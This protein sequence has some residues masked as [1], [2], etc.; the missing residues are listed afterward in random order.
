MSVKKQL[1]GKI[2]ECVPNFSEGRRKEVIE[3]IVNEIDSV[4]KIRVLDVHSDEDHNRSVVTFLGNPSAVVEAALGAVRAASRLIDLTHHEGVH[5]RIGAADVVPIIPIRDTTMED[6][7]NLAR[8]LARKISSEVGVPTY[9]YGFAA[10]RE[11]RKNLEKVRRTGFEEM[12]KLVLEDATY[13]PDFGGPS[14][15]STAGATVVG[16][17]YPLVAF[18]VNLD[19]DDLIAAKEIAEAIRE[20]NSGLVGLKALGLRLNKLSCVQVSTNIT[21]TDIVSPYTIFD[22]IQ[23][24]ARKRGIKVRNSEL[25]GLM[26]LSSVVNL[27]GNAM[28]LETFSKEKIIE[29]NI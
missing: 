2:V 8:D 14:L 24:E 28:H 21:R 25:I 13:Y 17:R 23:A 10:L 12:R 18:N 27:A 15:H 29:L 11:D 4:Q 9:L 26:P 22:R 19:S 16:A 5:P 6:C 3:A 1:K 20:K 7:V